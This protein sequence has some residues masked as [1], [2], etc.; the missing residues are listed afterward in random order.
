[1]L[2]I[3]TEVDEVC[4]CLSGNITGA[5]YVKENK[6]GNLFFVK[7]IYKNNNDKP[8]LGKKQNK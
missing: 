4:V 7:T 3:S 6:T 5:K 2:G 8:C 1:V